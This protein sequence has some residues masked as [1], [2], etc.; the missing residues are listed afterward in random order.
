MAMTDIRNQLLTLLAGV[1]LSL[2][3][4]ALMLVALGSDPI[5]VFETLI[6]GALRDS[7]SVA[8]TLNFAIP[9]ILASA[10]LVITFTAGLWNIGVEGQ[11]VMGAVFASW[12]AQVLALPTP[13]LVIVN[14]GLAALG[15]ALWAMLA[16]VLKTRLGV[17]EI[18][19]GVALN[20]IA[21]NIAIYLIAGPWQPPEGGSAQAT[22]PF[23]E[24][25]WLP[26]FSSDF[27]V[28]LLMLGITAASVVLVFVV[29]RFTDW[30]LQLKAVGNNARSALLLGVPTERVSLLAFAACGALAGL[31]GSHRVLHTYHSLRPLVAGGIGFLGLLVVLLVAYRIIWVPLVAI[32]AAGM[33]TGSSRLK[34][35]LRLDQSLVGVLQAVV[36]L[37]ILLVSGVRE[38]WFAKENR[39]SDDG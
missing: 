35:L 32:I 36:V 4:T 12:G 39:S 29:L 13:L 34:I 18:F 38:R 21:N 26:V 14:L 5:N 3:L 28:N 30:G 10:G 20:A 6:Q 37:M 9:L 17:H 25:A 7:R 27:P 15:G 8:A 23:P 31:A 33:F 11:I 16:G 1:G 19:G 22:P 24:A 2:L